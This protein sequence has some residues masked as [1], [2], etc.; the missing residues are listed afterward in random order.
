MTLEIDLLWGPRRKLFLVS[1]VPCT[2]EQ[3][4]PRLE[5]IRCGRVRS[6]ECLSLQGYF[7]QKEQPPP[8]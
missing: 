2:E 6:K 5:S 8:P 7:A 3:T 4:Q 1:E